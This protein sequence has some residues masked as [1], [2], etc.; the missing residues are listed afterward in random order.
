MREKFRPGFL[1]ER[2]AINAQE[3]ALKSARE[4]GVSPD[5]VTSMGKFQAEIDLNKQNNRILWVGIAAGVAGTSAW[6]L[7]TRIPEDLTIDQ[8]WPDLINAN[9]HMLSTI[10]SNKV[11]DIVQ[12][13]SGAELTI[14]WGYVV[15]A[16]L[17]R[18]SENSV[19]NLARKI[20]LRENSDVLIELINR[21]ES[22]IDIGPGH[23]VIDLGT[24]GDDIGS[25]LGIKRVWTEGSIPL[26]EGEKNVSDSPL[27]VKAHNP[28]HAIKKTEFFASLDRARFD[29]ASAFVICSLN[30]DQAFLPN[31]GKNDLPPSEVLD[32]I[33]LV[34]GY[35]REKG[36]PVK[37]V[38]VIGDKTVKTAVG[39]SYGDGKIK[40]TSE[41]SLEELI[42]NVNED[43]EEEVII[44]DPT[45]IA[46]S[47]LRDPLYN[48]R[49]LPLQFYGSP[50]SSEAYGKRFIER[51]NALGID[52]IGSDD[53]KRESLGIVYGD[54]DVDTALLAGMIDGR[55]GK[56]QGTVSVIIAEARAVGE[57][58]NTIVLQNVVSDW[59]ISR[60]LQPQETAVA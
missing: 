48:P 15:L 59:I 14:A 19:N 27:W 53:D 3:E 9:I 1:K 49:G 56:Y 44:A 20:R 40:T 47:L 30:Q 8:F 17:K 31:P 52:A 46:L 11:K 54:R 58:H 12:G 57:P 39:P 5:L 38:I 32:R 25:A 45:E 55:L 28:T 41:F 34:D 33:A 29:T 23:V 21:G 43:R 50:S 60:H 22:P 51:C 2:V 37:K 4:K 26:V 10:G 6:A 35:C 42:A 7:G 16:W 24:D 13:L 36:L 18:T